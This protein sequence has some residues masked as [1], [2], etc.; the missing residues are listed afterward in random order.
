MNLRNLAAQILL[1]VFKDG[2]SLTAALES[3]L[4]KVP[5]GKDRAFVQAICYGVC[6]DY[7]RLDFMLRQLLSKPLRNKDR[8]IHMLLLLGI[9]QLHAMRVQQHAAVSETVAA[10]KKKSWAKSLIN[11]VLRQYIRDQEALVHRLEADRQARFSHPEWMIEQFQRDWPAQAEAMLQANN[12]PAPMALRVNLRQGSREDYLRQLAAEQ[13][14]VRAGDFCETTIV[15][16]RPVNVDSLPGFAD[17]RVSVQDGAAQLAAQLLDLQAGQA[18]LDMCAAPGGKTAA[19]L[20]REPAL[21]TLLAV[22]IDQNR[23]SK[24]EENLQRLQLR[25]ELCVADA[26]QPEQWAQGRSFDRILLDAPCSALGV[27]R[28][29][30]DIKWLRRESD[31]DKLQR[32]QAKILNAAWSLLK[33][34][35]VLLYATCSVLKREN[36]AQIESFL[37]RHDEAAELKIVADW[38]QARP[39]G[40]QIISGSEQMD[41][42]YYAKLGKRH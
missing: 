11:G 2:Q 7:Y 37:A 41:G 27:I 20:E 18:V 25:A 1:R 26:A 15:L 29:H 14:E 9:Y 35:G 22:D 42:F 32:L 19:I 36:E 34:G 31:I 23:L 24:V 5:D 10:A 38:G 21:K 30:P 13:I 8:D 4:D 28:R 33:P 3:Q 6:R 40:R 17:G 16:E 39:F 12:Q